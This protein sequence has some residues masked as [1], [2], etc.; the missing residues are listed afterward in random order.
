VLVILSCISYAEFDNNQD[1]FYGPSADF[2]LGSR[3][4]FN[5]AI[6]PTKE[7]T[8]M[9]FFRHKSDSL[10]EQV[11][12]GK[13]IVKLSNDVF[14][15]GAGSEWA[16][17]DKDTRKWLFDNGYRYD[18]T[19]DGRIPANI[20]IVPVYDSPTKMHVR[21]PWKGDLKSGSKVKPKD[22]VYGGDFN[23]LLTKY[24]MRRCR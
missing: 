21:I 13:K 5:S 8:H 2:T 14:K 6:A 22:D 15:S 20:E 12:T 7:E 16:K 9:G 23:V 1:Q 17:F 24:F 18:G 3:C 19:P 11:K 4:R 10:A